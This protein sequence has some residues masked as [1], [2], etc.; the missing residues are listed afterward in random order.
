MTQFYI[1]A[2]Q[3][4]VGHTHE[5]IDQMF[6]VISR[7]LKLKRYIHTPQELERFLKEGVWNDTENVFVKR[8]TSVFD[9]VTAYL[10]LRGEGVVIR[11][12]G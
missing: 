9:F 5:D 10:G 7:K 12:M 11:G 8:V 6:S 1:E 2:T 4:F 3:S